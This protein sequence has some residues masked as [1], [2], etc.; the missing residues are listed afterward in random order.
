MSEAVFAVWSL[1][2]NRLGHDFQYF[3]CKSRCLRRFS[4]CQFSWICRTKCCFAVCD[5]CMLCRVF[6]CVFFCVVFVFLLWTVLHGV[7]SVFPL[8]SCRVVWFLLRSCFGMYYFPLSCLVL[9][10]C[11]VPCRALSCPVL[12]L[13]LF[14]VRLWGGFVWLWLLTWAV[15]GCGFGR[16]LFSFVANQVAMF[17]VMVVYMTI[18]DC[19]F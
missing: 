18:F 6:Y 10:C 19:G 16:V 9:L 5:D 7:V 11:V 3:P 1:A 17:V 12:H 4:R 8:L 2:Q 13:V 14:Y 15:S